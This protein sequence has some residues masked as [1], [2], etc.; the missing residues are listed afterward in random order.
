M[1]VRNTDA[2]WMWGGEAAQKLALFITGQRG[3][4][5]AEVTHELAALRIGPDAQGQG[6]TSAVGNQQ[7]GVDRRAG[8]HAFVQVVMVGPA[9]PGRLP[10]GN[11]HTRVVADVVGFVGV[12]RFL[13]QLE[14]SHAVQ[15]RATLAVH[16]QIVKTHTAQ[17]LGHGVQRVI[18]VA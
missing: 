12:H 16:R 15:H 10:Q 4:R 5:R 11:S 17:G 8:H 6:V 13:R 9:V 14:C 7:I 3:I 2:R 1:R 18:P